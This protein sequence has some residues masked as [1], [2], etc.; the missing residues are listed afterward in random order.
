MF[1]QVKK[2]KMLEPEDKLDIV[3]PETHYL[4][5]KY[6]VEIPVSD[7][8][9]SD[10]WELRLHASKLVEKKLGDEAQITSLKLKKPHLFKKRLAKWRGEVP[11]ARAYV[12]V[13]F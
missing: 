2:I 7:L 5:S 10:R 13:K 11:Y 8:N 9:F 4:S 6:V 12:T 3:P 1:K